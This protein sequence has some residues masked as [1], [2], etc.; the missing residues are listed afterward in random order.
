MVP[1][2]DAPARDPRGLVVPPAVAKR[3]SADDPLADD[4]AVVLVVGMKIASKEQAAETTLVNVA[5]V[6]PV[7]P[8]ASAYAQPINW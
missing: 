2:I 1:L 7:G 3:V 4:V 8:L 5:L 6:D